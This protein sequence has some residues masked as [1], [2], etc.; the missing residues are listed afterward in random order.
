MQ[1]VNPA[2]ILGLTLLV[3]MFCAVALHM[4]MWH[5]KKC[6]QI[7]AVTRKC[8]SCDGEGHK[9][10]NRLIV[11]CE[12]CGGRGEKYDLVLGGK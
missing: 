11:R 3:F 12:A 1:P 5:I 6:N 10:L 8:E 9:P 4:Y 7:K 2:T